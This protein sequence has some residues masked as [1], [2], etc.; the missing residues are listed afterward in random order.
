[1]I[2]IIITVIIKINDS[3][4]ENRKFFSNNESLSYKNTNG[5]VVA[6]DKSNDSN[7]TFNSKKSKN[8]V[9]LKI[10]IIAIIIIIVLIMKTITTIKVVMI[11]KLIALR[12][13]QPQK[14]L[15]HTWRQHGKKIQRL[16][17]NT[18]TEP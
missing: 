10:T 11:I 2:I 12:R 1:M 16:F 17:T 8:I 13:H 5:N 4:N 7:I 3:N 15:F 14:K 18:K 9:K 6:T